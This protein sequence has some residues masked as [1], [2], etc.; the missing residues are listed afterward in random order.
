MYFH[1]FSKPRGKNIISVY[2][3][4]HVLLTAKEYVSMYLISICISFSVDYL[5]MSINHWGRGGSI[6]ILGR[7][8]S[9][10]L[11]KNMQ[12]FYNLLSFDFMVFCVFFVC[13]CYAD[14]L[15]VCSWI[16]SPSY[17]VSK[18]WPKYKDLPQCL[19]VKEFSQ[20]F[21]KLVLGYILYI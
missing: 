21:V 12:F 6:Q 14:F 13:F 2:F 11:R 8:S 20:V 9:Y 1:F 15:M 18:I 19:V 7:I 17:V 10:Y 16:I 3:N 5:F 4:F